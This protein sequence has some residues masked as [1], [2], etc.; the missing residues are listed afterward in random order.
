MK[1]SELK[2][3][4]IHIIKEVKS[5]KV[6]EMIVNKDKAPDFFGAVNVEESE[7]DDEIDKQY[8]PEGIF[9]PRG[10]IKLGPGVDYKT[11]S[12]IARNYWDIFGEEEDDKGVWQFKTRGNA[13]CCA[14][15]MFNGKPAILSKT[16]DPFRNNLITADEMEDIFE[17][18]KSV[19]EGIL[20]WLKDLD[21][22]IDANVDADAREMHNWQRQKER[23]DLEQEADREME[24]ERYKRERERIALSHMKY[25]AVSPPEDYSVEE[26][27]GTGAVGGY[28]PPM[29]RRIRKKRKSNEMTNPDGTYSDD[30]DDGCRLSR[31]S[32][33]KEMTS[34][35]AVS[36][37]QVPAWGT[38]NKEGSPKA[39]AASKKLGYKVV[40]SIAEE[41]K[42]L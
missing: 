28:S 9:V 7:V 4:L 39:I 40:K 33:L 26:E 35:G 8:E 38:K 12:K 36:G 14:V 18:K 19:D 27:S 34:T 25:K 10:V 20:K 11:A 2:V 37:Y 15:G 13:Y 42:K 22:K 31:I 41:E 21:K 29:G 5:L 1:K 6:D 17:N 16:T 23:D 32:G 30:M 24:K 3:L